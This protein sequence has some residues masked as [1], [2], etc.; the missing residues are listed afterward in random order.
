MTADSFQVA[1]PIVAAGAVFL[2]DAGRVLLVHPTYK[3]HWDLPGGYVEPGESP[4]AACVREVREELS[5]SPAVGE[6]LVVDWAP[7]DGEG[8][9]LLFLFDGGR[10]DA[11]E[12][13]QIRLQDS[14]LD[15]WRYVDVDQ[16]DEYVPGRLSRR[17]R[18]AIAAR[19]QGRPAYAEHGDRPTTP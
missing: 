9:K 10:L 1:R 4:Y 19:E 7:A 12:V 13:E 17:I 18:T 8:D 5:I 11:G 6:H 14:E 16:L 15:R 2:D 3:S